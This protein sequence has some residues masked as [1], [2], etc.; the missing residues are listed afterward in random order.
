MVVVVDVD[1]GVVVDTLKV[2]LVSMR[3]DDRPTTAM[4]RHSPHVQ[5]VWI[6]LKSNK[7]LQYWQQ[8]APIAAATYWITPAY[9]EYSQLVSTRNLKMALKS[10]A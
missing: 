8:N 4:N 9:D 1:V 6:S 10:Q 7:L 5:A 3:V 2:E